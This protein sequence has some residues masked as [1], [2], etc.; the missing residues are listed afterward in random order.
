MAPV[1]TVDGVCCFCKTGSSLTRPA[2]QNKAERLL[3]FSRCKPWLTPRTADRHYAECRAVANL[4]PMD[5]AQ[6][7]HFSN[8]DTR[9]SCQDGKQIKD[10][11]TQSAKAPQSRGFL[12]LFSASMCFTPSG[13]ARKNASTFLWLAIHGSHPSGHRCAML[14]IIPDDFLCS[15]HLCVHPLGH[16]WPPSTCTVSAVYG[17][18]SKVR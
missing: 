18:S 2:S 16:F 9:N 5:V 4:L 7:A 13:L 14:K 15:A 12:F 17:L 11:S 6:E 8:R 3:G 1:T 10:V